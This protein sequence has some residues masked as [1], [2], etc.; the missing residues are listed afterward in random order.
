MKSELIIAMTAVWLAG[1]LIWVFLPKG[2]KNVA[3]KDPKDLIGWSGGNEALIEESKEEEQVKVEIQEEKEIEKG[4][5]G[6]KMEAEQMPA[7][8]DAENVNT[9]YVDIGSLDAKTILDT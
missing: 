9:K 3:F 5:E 6:K 2:K 4:R 1:G 7:R 8:N